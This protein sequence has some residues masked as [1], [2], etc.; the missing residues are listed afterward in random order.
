MHKTR[1]VC[2]RGARLSAPENTFASA[3]TA[4]KQGGSIIELDIRQSNDGVLYVMHDDTVDRTTNGTGKI[5]EMSSLQIDRLDAGGWFHK[6]F[7]GEVVPR[8]KDYLAK[9]ADRAG[10]YLEIKLADCEAIGKLVETLGIEDRCFTFSFDPIMRDGMLSEAPKIRRMIHWTT[11]GSP[12]AALENHNASIVEFHEHDFD[13][14][15]IKACQKAGLEVMF[16]T[17]R[18]D[19]QRFQKALELQMDYVNIDNL[20]EFCALRRGFKI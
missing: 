16:Y 5:S 20:E 18:P 8:L 19:M 7:T 15:R 9:F 17:D 1:I 10:F 14:V 12:Q 11:A 4:L 13:P 2:H 6:N 3:E